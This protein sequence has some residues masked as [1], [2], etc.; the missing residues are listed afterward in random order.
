MSHRIVI[1]IDVEA[2][3]TVSVRQEAPQRP[4]AAPAP[5][6]AVPPQET[7]WEGYETLESAAQ[8][9][10]ATVAPER[11]DK[12]VCGVHQKEMEFRPAGVSKRTGKPYRA[13]YGCPE[14]DCKVTKDAA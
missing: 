14:R 9:P 13:F 6:S 4:Q 7:A 5:L 8:H 2:G 12:P 10:P 1:T 3:G 11:H